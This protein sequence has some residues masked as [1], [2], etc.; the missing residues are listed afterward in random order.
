MSAKPRNYSDDWRMPTSIGVWGGSR[1]YQT[2]LALAVARRVDPDFFWL[3]TVGDPGSRDAPDPSLAGRVPSGHLFY[4]RLDQL[5]PRTRSGKVA[6]WFGRADIPADTRLREI[7]DSLR[8]PSLAR[9]LIEGRS[10]TS[11]T[12]ALAIAESNLAE[13]F[14]P[15][16]EGG[17]RPFIEALNHYGVTLIT[18][19]SNRPNPNARD[20]DYVLFIRPGSGGDTQLPDVECRQGPP[21]GSRGLFSQG[22]SRGL[23]ALVTEV[24]QVRHGPPQE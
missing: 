22:K 10:A 23:N 5:A 20:I 13:P 8:L 7:G 1:A 9:T 15:L 4:L 2:Q 14:L 21:P 16:E 18:T 11:P 6:D 12:K 19:I 3:Q 24:R 17:I